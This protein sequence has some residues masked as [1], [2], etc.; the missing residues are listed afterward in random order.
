MWVF[1]YGSLMWD[2]WEKSYGT[3]LSERATL[4]GYRRS[5]IKASVRNWGSPTQPGP[6]LGLIQDAA[7]RCEGIAF[8]FPMALGQQ[9]EDALR[10]R[11]G[12]SYQLRELTIELR[13]GQ[14][15]KA[16]VAVNDTSRRTFIGEQPLEERVRMAKTAQGEDGNCVDY[17]EEIHDKLRA[18]GI[19]DTA[20]NEFWSQVSRK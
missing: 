2:G 3:T 7:S 14:R 6:T 1:A 20:V 18:M 12:N 13:A 5:F 16:L 11:E 17:V 9:V 19:T 4:D 8:Q 10:K 15:V